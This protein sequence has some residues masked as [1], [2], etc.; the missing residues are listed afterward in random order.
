MINIAQKYLKENYDISMD[1]FIVEQDR[2]PYD[3]MPKENLTHLFIQNPVLSTK[4]VFQ[5]FVKQQSSY[6]YYGFADADII[7]PAVDSFCDQIA[8]HTVIKP[9][10]IQTFTDR[11]T[12]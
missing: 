3:Q 6:Q 11:W 1:I 7:I 4:G 8:E 2:E 10:S 9:R 12:R 5:C